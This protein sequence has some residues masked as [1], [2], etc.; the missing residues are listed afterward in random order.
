MMWRKSGK[1]WREFGKKWRESGKKWRESGK[2]WRESGKKWREVGKKWRESGKMWRESGKNG[3]S[4][5]ILRKMERVSKNGETLSI[6][7][8]SKYDSLEIFYIFEFLHLTNILK[9]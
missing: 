9:V 2:K 5:S 4:L 6:S 1:K 3:A 8:C 7:F